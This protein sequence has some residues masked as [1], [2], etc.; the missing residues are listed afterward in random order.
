MSAARRAFVIMP[1]GRK[2]L[3]DG[4][5]V[6]C[7]DIYKRLIRPAIDAAGLAAHRADADRRGGSIHLDM[8]QDLLLSEFVVADLTMDNPNVWYEIGVRHA[9]RSGGTVLTYANRDRLPFDIAGQRMQRYTLKDGKLDPDRLQPEC[10]ALTEAIVATL[11]AWRGRRAS[12]V[13]QTIPSLREP[14]WKTLKVGDVNEFWDALDA[15]RRRVEIARRNQRPGDILVL[16]DETPNSLLEFE[17]LRTAADALLKMNRPRY[18][19]QIVEQAR[20]LDPDDVKSAQIEGMAFGRAERFAEARDVLAA[21]ADKHKDGET[22]GLYARTWK[23]EWIQ[24]WDS[25]PQRQEDPAAAA[26]DTASTLHNAAAAYHDAFR[27]APGE[28][29]AGINALTLGRLWEHVTGLES[30]LPLGRI[31]SGVGWTTSVAVERDKDYW[32]L[33]TRAEMALVEG[34]RPEALADYAD[35]A[36]LA[37]TNR[38]RFALDSSKQQL[39]FVGTLGFRAEIVREALPIIE[40]AER[41][42][43]ALVGGRKPAQAEP[44]RV[45]VFSGHMIDNPDIR[46]PGKEKPARFPPEKIEPA[47]TVIR[48]RLDK[49]GAA[50]GDLGICGG[51]SGGDLLFA[52]ACLERGMRLELRLARREEE[53]LADSVTFADPDRRWE[54]SFEQVKES[55]ATTTLVMPQELGPTP[56]GVSV[57]DRCNRWMLYS[58]LSMGLRK[59][60]FITLWDG[61]PGDGPGGTEHMVE[62]VRKT[63]GRRP[64][65][66]DPRAL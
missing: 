52:E 17:A 30:K 20:K 60:Y 27:A 32:S 12:P 35:A 54:E 19:L 66:I 16:A 26:R 31:A 22:L 8:F 18:A 39:G 33:A 40:R 41:Q 65:I 36:A 13:Y 15:W 57:H 56:A 61:A 55:K 9:L 10:Q 3:T 63:T 46:G 50:A 44:Q 2:K 59:T 58:A 29:Y 64:E 24:I 45:V 7:D 23:D 11:G 38:D 5:E 43:D 51:A 28:Y 34:R 42:L 62:L 47:A 48:Q 6:D 53:F 21:L 49:V 37:V 4:T 25:H 1:F 14:D